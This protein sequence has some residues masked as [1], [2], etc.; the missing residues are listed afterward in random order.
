MK[1]MKKQ[2]LFVVSIVL[3]A[4]FYAQNIPSYVPTNGLVG[5]WPF[6]GNANDES[7]NG[8]HGTVYGATL[9]SDRNGEG[10]K[11]YNFDGVDD[12]INF[13]GD[14][15]YAPT[16]LKTVSFSFWIKNK[17]FGT[18]LSKYYNLDAGNSNFAFIL[19]KNNSEFRI[20]GNGTNIISTNSN[21]F[22][23]WQHVVGIY[24][25]NNSISNLYVNGLFV[26]SGNVNLNS[27]ISSSDLIAGKVDGPLPGYFTGLIDDIAIY[28]RV[29]SQQEITAL[30]LG[31]SKPSAA[32]TPKSTTNIKENES[33]VLAA[34]KGNGYTYEWYKDGVGIANANDSNY[35]A[36]TP[37]NYTVKISTS[38]TCDSTSVAVT[39]K[40]AYALPNN[41]PT[42]GLLGWWPFNGNANDESGNENHGTVNGATLTSDRNGRLNRAYSFDGVDDYILINNSSTLNPS[43]ITLNVWIKANK[44]NLCI[45]EKGNVTNA[46]EHSFAL[47]HNDYWQIQRGLKSSFSNG[48]CSTTNNNMVWGNYNEISNHVWAM[49][50][51]SLDELGTINQ[52]INGQL[53]NTFISNTPLLKC[54]LITSTLRFGGPHWDTDPEWFDGLIDDIAIFNRALTL[55]EITALYLGDCT[56]PLAAMTPKSTTNIK[57]NESVVLAATKGN[58]YTYTWYKDGVGIANA[59]DSNYT[60]TTPGNYTVKISTSATCDST[61]A[62]VTVK[63]VYVLPTY[64]PS[65]GLVGW[66][67]FNGNANDESGNGNHGT[68][69][70]ATLISDRKGNVNAAYSFDGINDYIDLGKWENGGTFS[71]SIWVNYSK[72]QNNSRLLDFGNGENNN[73]IVIYNRG[74]SNYFTYY[75]TSLKSNLSSDIYIDN[76]FSSNNWTNLIIT[77]DSDK[78]IKIYKNNILIDS[79]F[80]NHL[81]EKVFRNKQ[82]FGK[83]NW[84]IDDYLEGKLDDIAMYNRALS[85]E[86]ITALYLG[87]CNAFSAK[88]TPQGLT[89]VCQGT[90]VVLNANSGAG[91]T[92]VWKRNNTVITGATGASFSATTSGSYEVEITTPSGCKK[93]SENVIVIVKPRPAAGAIAGVNYVC[94]GTSIKLTPTIVGGVWSVLKPN[95]ASIDQNGNVTGLMRTAQFVTDVVAYTVTNAEGCVATAKRGLGIDS[96]P[97]VPII[98]GPSKIC[99]N[100]TVLYRTTNTGNVSWTAGPLLSASSAYQ[101]VFTHR[102]ASNGTVPSDNY[103]TF[104]KATSY[105]INKVCKSE[106]TKS[107]QLRTYAS[108]SITMISPSS[109][110]VNA[111]TNV[112]VTFPSGLTTANTS[113]RFW[114]SSASSVMSVAATSNLSTTVKALNLP[115]VSPRLYFSAIENSTGCAITAYKLFTVRTVS[116]VDANTT[117]TVST[118]GVH[119][120]PNPSNGRFT[121]E[122]SEEATEIK[123]VDVTGRIIATHE[124]TAGTTT[125][126]FSGVTA[127]KYMVHLN[128]ETINKVQ[129]IIIE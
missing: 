125:V 54:D 5:W 35:T 21:V 38:A 40:R 77:L 119:I 53:K 72:F 106:A 52:Y 63:R 115:T 18:I 29:L 60:A 36:T 64:L 13:G 95:L 92:Y 16:T 9:T 4:T 14:T 27:I 117:Q 34:T 120:Y 118:N 57:E 58:G 26:S 46:R 107:V 73:N 97:V 80:I 78:N 43:N 32:I 19:D 76:F 51:V 48:E 74:K 81:P 105:S 110:V 11:A 65:N 55:E 93:T 100:G 111:T 12:Y 90:P 79:Q 126:D 122:N 37:G 30:Y 98:A 94:K 103:S 108:K 3:T 96:L 123:L 114:V 62:A 22:E 104:V 116:L 39:V 70:G 86:E 8:N 1:K 33:V 101:G 124:I 88:I 109:L 47:T 99:S 69:N 75:S 45:L 10:N 82:Y 44:D 15:N 6:N 61:S 121:I 17:G 25:L 20:T 84:Q 66:W 83:S 87:E 49:I 31:C 23:T 102:V 68:V 24:N 128:G 91:L 113:S 59:T 127:G 71:I 89:T 2:L 129:S 28:N 112:S 50:T 41:L 7:G 42:N 67:P 85:Q 56:K